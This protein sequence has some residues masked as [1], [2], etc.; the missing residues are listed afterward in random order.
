MGAAFW[1]IVEDDQA[2]RPKKVTAEVLGEAA[3][4]ARQ[5]GGHVEAVWLAD[6]ATDAGLKQLAEWGATRVWLLED[7][8]FMPYRSEVWAPAVAEVAEKEAPRAIFGAV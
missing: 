4:L 5:A 3:R 8:A 2:G 1:C 6:K 7:P